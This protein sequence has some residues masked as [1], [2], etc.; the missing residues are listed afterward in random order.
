MTSK[1]FVKGYLHYKTIFY[2]KVALMFP[3]LEIYI[4]C[5]FVKSLDFKICDVVIGIVT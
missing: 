1:K 5:V 4:F 3:S 2:N